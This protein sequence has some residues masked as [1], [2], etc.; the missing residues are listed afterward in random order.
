METITLPTFQEMVDLKT[1]TLEER[2]HDIDLLNKFDGLTAGI[3]LC[4]N[5]YIQHYFFKEMAKVKFDNKP[6][7]YE[8]MNNEELKQK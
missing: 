7:L 5:K 2:K 1:L 8:V 6:S 3:K 4:G